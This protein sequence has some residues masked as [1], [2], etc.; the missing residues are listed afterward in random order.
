MA[1][2][3]DATQKD[4]PI[5]FPLLAAAYLLFFC[6]EGILAVEV[7]SVSF[8]SDSIVFLEAA[9]VSVLLSPGAADGISAP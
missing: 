5:P 6:L 4:P 8:F 9:A 3:K 7:R 2:T 1:D